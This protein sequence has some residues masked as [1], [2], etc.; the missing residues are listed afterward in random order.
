MKPLAVD[1]VKRVHLNIN[2]TKMALGAM[3]PMLDAC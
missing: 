2:R 1:T 3:W